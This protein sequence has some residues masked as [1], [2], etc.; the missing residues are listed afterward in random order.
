M[1]RGN[2]PG[3]IA[4][5][6]AGLPQAARSAASLVDAGLSATGNAAAKSRIAARAL[7]RELEAAEPAL[8]AKTPSVGPEQVRHQIGDTTPTMVREGP[9]ITATGENVPTSKTARATPSEPCC[10]APGTLVATEAG[11]RPIETIEVGDLV[12]TRLEDGTGQAF[13]APVTAT[14]IRHDRPILRLSVEQVQTG[15]P[16]DT[17]QP[18]T[19]DLLVTPGHPFYVAGQGFVSVE[20]L[21][22][23]DE[24]VSLGSGKTLRVKSLV[25][26]APQGTTHNL[27]VDEGHTFF[28]GALGTWVHNVGPCNTCPGGGCG[29]TASETGGATADWRPTPGKIGNFSRETTPWGRDVW[30]RGDIDWSLNRPDGMNNMDAALAGLSPVRKV[31]GSFEKIELHHLNQNPGGGLVEVYAST[32]RKINHNAP[33]PSWR[34]TDPDANSAFRREVP[35]YWRWTANE[36]ISGRR[37]K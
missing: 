5:A 21:Q 19:E 30:Q 22:P 11:E 34:V 3:E 9:K 6:V 18:T 31:G 4:L 15:E 8:A 35:S 17:T 33:R 27:T 32:H 23:G 12:W 14:H 10:F 36:L 26:E 29:A 25:L 24:L 13:L 1:L 16:E 7:A 37:L 28:V 20:D 2:Y